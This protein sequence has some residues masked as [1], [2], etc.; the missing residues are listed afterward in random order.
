[1]LCVTILLPGAL[2]QTYHLSP[3]WSAA[4]GDPLKLYVTSTGGA[5]TPNER[6]IAFNALS[7][8]LY[9]VQRSGN[10]YTVHVVDAN[11]G[12][13]LYNLRT[14]GILPVVTSEVSG[15]NGIGLVAIDAAADGAVY[16][17]NE[18]PNASGGSN[19]FSTNKLFRMYRWA[20]SD[21]NTLP[22]EIF[23]GDPAGQSDNFRGGDV[24][25]AR[26][27]GLNIQIILDNQNASARFLAILRPTDVTMKSF[28]ATFFFQDTGTPFG[29]SIG[30][31]L[32]FGV[33]DTLWQKRTAAPLLQ[34]SFDFN[35]SQ[36]ISPTLAAY[37]NFPDSLGPVGLDLSRNLLAG[38][39][40]AS[41]T[42]TPDT[43]DLYDISDPAN[44]LLLA[45]Y[46]FSINHVAN[47]NFIGRVLFAGD[48]VF[49]LDGN[50]GILAFAVASGPLAPPTI[51][52]QPQSLR[53]VTGSSGTLSVITADI[54]TF[55]WQFNRT[56]IAG[57]TNST[58]TISN[59]R[60]S[61][62]GDYRVIVSNDAGPA[63]SSNAVVTVLPGENF[64]RLSPLWSLAPQ[65]RDYLPGDS[66]GQ[67]RT[68][69]YRG[70]AYNSL[71]NQ[72]YLISR[73]G[74]SDGLSINVLDATTGLDL[75][76][77]NTS[78]ISGGSIIL[79]AMGAGEDGALYAANMDT[80]ATTGAAVYNLYRW[81]NSSPDTVPT[82]VFSGEPAGLT[83]PF[84]WGDTMAVR[85]AATNTE[86]LIDANAGTL[87][88]LLTP[89]DGT[90]GSFISTSFSQG[91]GSGTIGRSLQFGAGSAFWQKRKGTQLRSST[92]DLAGQSSAAVTNYNSFPAS[93][94]PVGLD[95]TRNLLAGIDFSNDINAPDTLDFYDATDFNDPLLVAK[96]NFPVNSQPNGNFIGQVV[97][98]GNLVFAVD[99]NNGILAFTIVP[100]SRPP[101][102][103]AR[104][105]ANA[106]LS[107]TSSATGFALQK[108]SS[109]SPPDWAD[110]SQTPDV[111]N[112]Q[113]TITNEASVGT[114]FY[115]L[116]KP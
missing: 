88:A 49:A 116:R 32:E 2:G 81:G 113:N 27:S 14:N 92:Y 99:G 79:L 105:G 96:Y 40:F 52:Q 38:I 76:Q 35:A 70:I 112:G 47:N 58:Y 22:V 18:S 55:Q 90:M 94:G 75:Y 100:P 6:G 16:A 72:V 87:A 107:W 63:A 41:S 51:L 74:P 50:N 24:L 61:D 29:A 85:G 36:N 57:A 5:G 101:L 9:V 45:Q 46:N 104:A 26:G 71:S 10:N 69:L 20:N 91:Y 97:F 1:M 42:S 115:R 21:S 103:I 15:A 39:N 3:L 93:L 89:A 56:N 60:F 65:S 110:V 67:G 11:A 13:K 64:H 114:A 82:P 111:V 28:S 30:R 23:E 33:G 109:L 34:S 62:A 77:L 4:P 84:R 95:L 73:T 66:D 8:Q 54:A 86:I 102:T 37:A 31:S 59:A 78:G 53:L 68:P 83:S 43:L 44:P 19:P 106:V 48:K 25:D 98:A 17:G 80:S 7:N 12:T 108:T